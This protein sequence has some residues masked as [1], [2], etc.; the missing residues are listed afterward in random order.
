MRHYSLIILLFSFF[1]L[2]NCEDI[3]DCIINVRPEL[4]D[5]ALA[6][7]SFDNYYY[8][9]ITAQIKNEPRD[10]DYE[11]YFNVVGKLP[12][13]IEVIYYDREVVFEG[14]PLETGRFS[15]EIFLE[16]NP[17]YNTYNYDGNGNAYYDDALCTDNT[18]KL[19]TLIVYK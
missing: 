9:R 14:T 12:R 8:D 11:Y 1:S 19:Y 5:K 15:F 16:V 2:T 4:A 13:G 17:Y 6:T 3:V 10:N 7:G 18:S